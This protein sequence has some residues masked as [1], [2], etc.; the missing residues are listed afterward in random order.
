[1]DVRGGRGGY[2][3]G[4]PRHPLDA[5]E[6]LADD[7]GPEAA[8]ATLAHHPLHDAPEGRLLEAALLARAGRLEPSLAVL[9]RLIARADL[10]A[11]LALE[12]RVTQA[13]VW[14]ALGHYEVAVPQLRAA[15]RDLEAH[16]GLPELL[17]DA[18]AELAAYE[19]VSGG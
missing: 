13:S 18:R 15:V 16:G 10:E 9:G 19:T 6:D 11:A 7:D 17:G 14:A 3:V 4:M 12:A 1:M 5:I 2:G 8:L